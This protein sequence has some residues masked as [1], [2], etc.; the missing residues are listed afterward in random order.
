[1][2]LKIDE[3]Q[4]SPYNLLSVHQQQKKHFNKVIPEIYG[5]Y[6]TFVLSVCKYVVIYVMHL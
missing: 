1:M 4:T 6:I 5:R 2:E 3:C